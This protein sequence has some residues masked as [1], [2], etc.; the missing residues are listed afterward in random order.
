MNLKYEF[1]KYNLNEI[2]NMISQKKLELPKFQRGFSWDEDTQKNLIVS[3]MNG[4]PI[5]MILL[6]EMEDSKKDTLVI[7]DG[8]QRL[9]TIKKYLENP[10]QYITEDIIDEGMI[11]AIIREDKQFDCLTEEKLNTLILNYKS[12]LLKNIIEL[13]EEVIENNANSKSRTSYKDYFL[14]NKERLL[15]LG[16]DINIDT[17]LII[18]LVT[19]LSDKLDLKDI[20]IPTT[21]YKGNIVELADLFE[22]VNSGSLP[23]TKYEI[24][25]AKWY[26]KKISPSEKVEKLVGEVYSSIEKEYSM[27]DEDFESYTLFDY[28]LAI[29]HELTTD[30][31]YEFF[32]KKKNVGFELISALLSSFPNEIES[33]GVI[34]GLV[35][36]S[37]FNN[38]IEELHNA[39]ISTAE[40]MVKI[41]DSVLKGSKL[42]KHMFTNTYQQYHVFISIFFSKYDIEH[43][44]LSE[45]KT[46][47]TRFIRDLSNY[48]RQKNS[49]TLTLED[50]EKYSVQINK[51]SS[52]NIKMLNE[53]ILIRF[54]HM[55]CSDFYTKNRQVSDFSNFVQDDT[56]R[57]IYFTKPLF[58]EL[59]N[60]IFSWFSEQLENKKYYKRTIQKDVKQFAYLYHLLLYRNNSE[61]KNYVDNYVNFDF[62]H[63]CPKS[64]FDTYDVPV[65][66]AQNIRLVDSST[67]RKKADKGFGQVNS[68]DQKTNL[69][70]LDMFGITEED[71]MMIDNLKIYEK[72]VRKDK[73]NEMMKERS[74]IITK[75]I[76]MFF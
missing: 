68:A 54:M 27:N 25:N 12:V 64:L 70:F 69:D 19:N 28:C 66:C 4:N 5:G 15:N 24:L 56:L 58:E 49:H 21:I 40:S 44:V 46:E 18:E 6:A 14:A 41:Y 59:Q 13:L 1:E 57:N 29:N 7:I 42:K 61:Y 2:I 20:I 36:D 76:E 48:K 22:K 71:T 37:E 11:E 33:L 65:S 43:K 73:F 51:K 23:L 72:N 62:D 30:K 50:K 47:H 16:V 3:I 39:I 67:N 52:K 31:K 32:Y 10:L 55:L 34:Q 45:G 75:K 38:F 26:E 17:T 8:Q 9:S 60:H 35:K 74:N 53:T 63:I